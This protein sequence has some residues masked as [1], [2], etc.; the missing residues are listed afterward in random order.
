MAAFFES[1]RGPD[2]EGLLDVQVLD[3]VERPAE[4]KRSPWNRIRQRGFRLAARYLFGATFDEPAHGWVVARFDG[5]RMKALW[6]DADVQMAGRKLRADQLAARE[7]FDGQHDPTAVFVAAGGPIRA[8]AERGRLSVL[9]VASLVAYLAGELVPDDLEGTL[10]R[11]WIDPAWLA[12][13]PPRSVPASQLPGLV[14]SEAAPAA[15]VGDPAMLER[16][17]SLGYVE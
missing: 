5:D 4:R 7:D 13:H 1:A 8:G 2:G 15:A 12:A 16:L 17:R 11:D 14:P 6:P 3:G 9:D 10:P